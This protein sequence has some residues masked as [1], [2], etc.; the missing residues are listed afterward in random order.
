MHIEFTFSRTPEYWQGKFTAERSRI[1]TLAGFL[2]P[3]VAILALFILVFGEFSPAAALT[4]G[5]L[6]LL[7]VAAGVL[8]RTLHR[9]AARDSLRPADALLTPRTWVLTDETLVSF[10]DQS[11]A[12]FP[13]SSFT[14]LSTMDDTYLLWNT[15]GKTIDIPREPLTPEQDAELAALLRDR[16]GDRPLTS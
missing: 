6:V 11:S 9:R 8:A 15:S 2:V 3:P 7:A 14:A 13:W 5:A 10:T 16:V 4:G 1:G 12:E